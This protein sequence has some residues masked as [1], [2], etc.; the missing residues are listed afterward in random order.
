MSNASVF[1]TM[2]G[3]MLTESGRRVA[4]IMV[5]SALRYELVVFTLHRQLAE[6]EQPRFA[7]SA[8]NFQL[9]HPVDHGVASS[10]S[11]FELRLCKEGDG[12]SVALGGAKIVSVSNP[13]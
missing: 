10:R 8:L 6:T 2:I 1:D 9:S 3:P 7:R 11:G 5:D 12:F 13:A 4:L